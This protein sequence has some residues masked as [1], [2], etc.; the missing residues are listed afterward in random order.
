MRR[1]ALIVSIAAAAGCHASGGAP[2]CEAVAGRFYA[3][4][5]GELA[6]APAVDPATARAVSDQLPAM[7][8]ALK[9]SCKDNAW[10]A[11]VRTCMAGAADHAAMQA[12]ETQLTAAQRAALESASH[13]EAAPTP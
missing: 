6:T 3:L 11:E 13:G 4:A 8:D 2:A 1:F 12:C 5:T 9:D 10:S 7:R